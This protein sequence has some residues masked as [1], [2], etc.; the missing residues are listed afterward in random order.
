MHS[1]TYPSTPYSGGIHGQEA[2][3]TKPPAPAGTLKRRLPP[4]TCKKVPPPPTCKNQQEEDP[5]AGRCRR[6]QPAGRSCRPS[7]GGIQGRR[8]LRPAAHRRLTPPPLFHRQPRPEE[9][10]APTCKKLSPLLQPAARRQEIYS[11]SLLLYWLTE[12]EGSSGK[13]ARKKDA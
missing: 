6:P 10:T 1:S 3:P 13:I 7:S 12:G 8:P 2:A 4:P 11:T 9:A 5:P